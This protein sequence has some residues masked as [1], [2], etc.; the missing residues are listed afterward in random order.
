MPRKSK[1]SKEQMP[2]LGLL[3]DK[4]T[5]KE[6]PKATVTPELEAGRRQDATNDEKTGI[7]KLEQ[8]TG[9]SRRNGPAPK[10]RGAKASIHHHVIRDEQIIN[11][12]GTLSEALHRRRDLKQDEGIDTVIESYADAGECRRANLN[13]GVFTFSERVESEQAT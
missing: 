3:P 8:A 10:R 6:A 11:C 7:S 2:L 13:Y 1:V 4:S 12:F 9:K 5:E